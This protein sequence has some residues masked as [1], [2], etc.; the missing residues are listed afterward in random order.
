[1]AVTSTGFWTRSRLSD[2]P[3][4]EVIIVDDGSTDPQTL[5]VIDRIE[6]QGRATVIRQKRNRGPSVARN[7]AIAAAAGRYILPV[8]A[9][10]LLLAGAVRSLVDQLQAA[11]EQVGYVY[12]SFQYFGTRDYEFEPPAYNLFLLLHRNFIDTCSLLDRQVF[13]ARV[14]YAEDI[15][16]GH[17]DWDLALALGARGVIGQPSKAPVMLYR[18]QGFTRSDLVEY[19]RRPFSQEIQYRHPEL[20]GAIDVKARWNP[21]LSIVALDPIDFESERGS[22]LLRGLAEQS[23]RDFELIAEC[24]RVPGGAQI[25]VRRLPPGLCSCDT[26]RAQ[27]G[28][29]IRRGRYLML[30]SAPWKLF[31]DPTAV[32]KLLRGFAFQDELDAV[33]LADFGSAGRYPFRRVGEVPAA[34]EAHTIVWRQELQA[35]LPGEATIPNGRPAPELADFIYAFG[36]K[37]QWRHFPGSHAKR[38][39]TEPRS[40]LVLRR[41]TA[42]TS[43]AA[44]AEREL[45]LTQAPAL[46]AAPADCVPRWNSLPTWM[47]PESIFLV[48]HRAV[49]GERR[50]VTN[51]RLSPP[52]FTI[53]LDLGSI[54]HFSPPGTVRLL[55]R[56]GQFTTAPRGTDREPEDTVLGYLEQAPLPLLVGLERVSL[57]DGSQTLVLASERDPLHAMAASGTFL[58]FIEPFPIEPLRPP[59]GSAVIAP[60][61]I[62]R[63][64]RSARRHRY[65]VASDEKLSDPTAPSSE[66]GVPLERDGP[67]RIALWID[68]RG[69][70][71]TGDEAMAPP[72][73]SLSRALRW[74]G[75]PVSWHDLGDT[76][77]RERAIAR[78]L[79]DV[80]ARG[81][82]NLS[83]R[84]SRWPRR[85]TAAPQ[86]RV[87]GYLDRE[88][89]PGRI[90]LFAATHPVV[91]DQF[92]TP[93]A[94]EATDMGYERVRSLGFIQA[95]APLTGQ[96]GGRAVAIPW[97]SRFGLSARRG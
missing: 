8:D 48:R 77:A 93:Y 85:S 25:A 3:E 69:W 62:R 43:E 91:E 2:Y 15:E 1:M 37:V 14:K 38:A 72:A 74:A 64:D 80:A 92:V 9:D 58:G 27:E 33:A 52:G 94:I 20:F 59:A 21:A 51:D 7:R 96:L 90:E 23:C 47:P 63:V 70:L 16:L 46:P 68:D 79:W 50:V 49:G 86:R 13:D 83:R 29:D 32:E 65:L 22:H 61:L 24:P 71:G 54:Q 40:G 75:A 35:Q 81:G 55:Y 31:A 18:K 53:E 57:P 30:T 4:L 66:L 12:P 97:V 6:Q 19:H 11:G 56:D 44:R 42:A 95:R 76:R 82:I 89:G 73:P 5:E 17:E 10:N 39:P 45:R 36:A 26:A 88:P 84:G 87:V 41:P 67:G 78:R 60:S 28:L 34:T